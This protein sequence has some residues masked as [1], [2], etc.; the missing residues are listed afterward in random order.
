MM[1]R[2]RNVCPFAFALLFLH[3]W[4]GAADAPDLSAQTAR[5]I[6]AE[7]TRPQTPEAAARCRWRRTGA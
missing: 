1:I 7:A 5:E 3:P 6:T 4:A 2:I